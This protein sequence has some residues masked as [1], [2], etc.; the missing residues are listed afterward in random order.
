MKCKNNKNINHSYIK[1]FT[2]L[3]NVLYV[4]LH[5]HVILNLYIIDK[6][7][8]VLNNQYDVLNINDM[9]VFNMNLKSETVNFVFSKN[10]YLLNDT[11]DLYTCEYIGYLSASISSEVSEIST[12]IF[13]DDIFDY[14]VNDLVYISNIPYI[15]NIHD[16]YTMLNEYSIFINHSTKGIISGK[17]MNYDNMTNSIQIKIIEK[18]LFTEILNITTIIQ[19]RQLI[20]EG[21]LVKK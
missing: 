11:V 10:K 5:N 6:N 21:Q 20:I 19:N 15:P 4:F 9:Y 1:G 14:D 13:K 7:N 2:I 8:K 18:I 12:I 16:I 17:Y 3:D